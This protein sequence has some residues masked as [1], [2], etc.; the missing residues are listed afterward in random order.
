MAKHEKGRTGPAEDEDAGASATPAGV[1]GDRR[2]GGEGFFRDPEAL[3]ALEERVLT[4][5]LG[6]QSGGGEV[7]VWVPACASGEEAYSLAILMRERTGSEKGAPRL[8]IFATDQE[9]RSIETARLAIYPAEIAANMPKERLERSFVRRRS[10]WQ[11]KDEICGTC[12]FSVHDLDRD[13]PFS[14]IDLIVCR[15]L[16]IRGG[17]ESRRRTMTLF[18]YA[19]R[20][21]GFLMLDRSGDI[22][23]RNDLYQTV[24]ET[25]RIYQA[26]PALAR[27]NTHLPLQTSAEELQLI[28]E[29]EREQRAYLAAIVESSEDAILGKTL[30]GVITFWNR[31]SE[32]MYGWTREEALGRRIHDLIVPP[33][34]QAELEEVMAKLA[35]GEAIAPFET[36]RR[37]KDG[38]RLQIS[39]TI[40]PIRDTAGQVIGAST[41]ARDVTHQREAEA[42][43]RASEERLRIALE[44]GRMG[45]WEWDV[46]SGGVVWSPGLERIHGR[47]AGS[48]GGTFADFQADMH[49]EDAE[50]VLATI[51]RALEERSDYQVEYRIVRPDRT[52]AWLEARGRIFLDERGEP[53]RMAGVCMDVSE[54]KRA[55]E[56]LACHA[57]E[58]AR[59]NA[60]LEQFAYA[61]SHDLQ[62]PLR[63]IGAYAQ[64]LEKRYRGQLDAQAEEF[65]GFVTDGVGRMHELIE[66]LLAYCRVGSH[67]LAAGGASVEEALGEALANLQTLERETGA[68]IRNGELPVVRANRTELIQLLQNLIGNAL[69]FRSEDPPKVELSARRAGEFWE[70]AVRDNG[71]GMEAKHTE[72][73]FQIFQRLH[74]R[75][76]Y[77]GAGVG[78]A[79]CKKIVERHGGKIWVDS[80]PGRGSTF[81]FTLPA[82]PEG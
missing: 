65:I 24:D 63:M 49:P 31:G 35:R 21:G 81:F 36:V 56:E 78:L 10:E 74:T 59:S 12:V 44:A 54:R 60:E 11:V 70:L 22:G 51:Q 58:L 48:F 64:L 39:V 61:A 77:P 33:E 2:S 20:P 50:R 57:Q 41:I 46:R 15:N 26:M 19:L 34:R 9:P 71:I 55:E 18:H 75:A 7:R 8:R 16:A 73:I 6:K 17:P 25:H 45:T 4:P 76:R 82:V 27:T 5:L 40:S 3:R 43:L 38:R 28:L 37:R 67:G 1:A 69:K 53:E 32:R 80:T 30:E 13:P 14:R 23:G 66:G 47:Q 72:R 42:S 52:I 62:E 79:I 29:T 68:E